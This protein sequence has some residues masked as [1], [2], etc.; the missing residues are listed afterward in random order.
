MGSLNLGDINITDNNRKLIE[1][2]INEVIE[3][4]LYLDEGEEQE[5]I[6]EVLGVNWHLWD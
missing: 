5:I 3:S 4:F 6:E 2:E 1:N